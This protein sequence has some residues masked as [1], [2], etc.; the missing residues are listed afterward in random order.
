MNE[1]LKKYIELCDKKANAPTKE[2]GIFWAFSQNQFIEGYEDLVNRGLISRGDKISR[3][4]DRGMF[5][6]DGSFEKLEAY[7]DELNEEIRTSIPPQVVYDYE[8][9]NYECMYSHEDTDVIEI[10]ISIYGRDAAK[11]MKRRNGWDD[12]DILADRMER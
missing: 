4:G 11:G 3:Y 1:L 8:Y 5:G 7:F 12:I 2:M 10:I 9:R 6:I